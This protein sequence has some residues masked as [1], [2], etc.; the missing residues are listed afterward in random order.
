MRGDGEVCFLRI[1]AEDRQLTASSA[2]KGRLADVYVPALVEGSLEALSRRLGNRATIE[3]PLHG[4]ASSLSSIDPLLEKTATRLKEARATYRHIMSTT[5]V[6]RDVSEGLLTM[7]PPG[8][9]DLVLCPVMVVAERRRLRE[10]ELR[11]YYA[12]D[13]SAP[14]QPR[15]PLLQNDDLKNVPQIVAHILE[16]L[17]KGAIERVLSA[18]EEGSRFVD[19]R[20]RVA[21]KKDGAMSTFLDELGGRIDLVPMGTADD[22]RTCCVEATLPTGLPRKGMGGPPPMRDAE[23]AALA[24]ERGDSGLIR[25]LRFYYEP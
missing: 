24:F 23:S 13:P 10:I 2:L 9:A 3:D 14:R 4:R 19:P 17:R 20:G 25:E 8:A 21:C 22:G 16:A 5:G 6:D 11:L 15:V 7:Q 18:F 1:M 12:S